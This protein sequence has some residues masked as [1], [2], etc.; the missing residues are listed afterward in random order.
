MKSYDDDEP[1][2]YEN[3]IENLF[4]TINQH[5]LEV[6]FPMRYAEI[7]MEPIE[8]EKDSDSDLENDLNFWDMFLGYE[9]VVQVL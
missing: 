7:R 9:K 8:I 3:G 5:E 1:P 2:P 4:L 6:Y